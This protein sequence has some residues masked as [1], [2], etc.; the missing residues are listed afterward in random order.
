MT[1]TATDRAADPPLEDEAS[2]SAKPPMDP[3]RKWTFMVLALC[4]VLLIW[5][6]AADRITPYSTQ[7]RIH[8]LVVPV[9]PEVSGTVVALGE[10]VTGWSRS[11]NRL[12]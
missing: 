6:L 3:V 11:A 7:A 12:I 2:A 8:A 5:Y 4:A 1:D 9:A 10:A